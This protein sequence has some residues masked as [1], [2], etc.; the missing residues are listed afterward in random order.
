MDWIK[1]DCNISNPLHLVQPN[2]DLAGHI[3]ENDVS[4]VESELPG[5]GFRLS[6]LLKGQLLDL[7]LYL[8]R[9]LDSPS[10]ADQCSPHLIWKCL[11]SPY[12][13]R[14]LRLRCGGRDGIKAG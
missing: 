10:V 3:P 5:L 2:N 9:W 12:P 4:A 13:Q 7:L 11:K 8:L 6:L 1:A 14:L